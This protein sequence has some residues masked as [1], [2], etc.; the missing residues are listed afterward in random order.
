[1]LTYNGTIFTNGMNFIIGM[2]MA[3][4]MHISITFIRERQSNG[5]SWGTVTELR[6][7]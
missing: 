5:R 6:A 2:H 1:M 4:Q 3:F 7:W